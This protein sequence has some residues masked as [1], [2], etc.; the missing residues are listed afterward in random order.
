M[1]IVKGKRSRYYDE[2]VIAFGKARLCFQRAGLAE[3]WDRTVAEVRA[4]HRRKLGFIA[5]FE[6]LLAGD[7]PVAKP[8]FLERAKANWQKGIPT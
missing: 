7:E 3:E 2:A 5:D 4:E 6:R 1:R 8:S